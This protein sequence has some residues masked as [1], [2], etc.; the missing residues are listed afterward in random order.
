MQKHARQLAIKEIIFERDIANQEL[1]R[2]ELKRRGFSVTQATLSRDLHELGVNRTPTGS[3]SKY[4]LSDDN[5][6]PIVKPLTGQ[7]IIAIRHN[8]SLIVIVTLPGFASAT[9]QYIDRQEYEHIL[10]TI[11]GD[12]T[13]LII[14]KSK[15]IIPSLMKYLHRLLVGA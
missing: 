5:V 12:D 9:A 3:G 6:G 2:R 10:G 14:P 1:L 4:M 7:E 15:M 11:A 8:E 13:I